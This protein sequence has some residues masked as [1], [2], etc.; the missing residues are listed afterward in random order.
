MLA[1]GCDAGADDVRVERA[2]EPAV[3]G[4]QQ[5]SDLRHALVLFEDRQVGDVPGRF[6]RLPRHPP[7]R[8]GVGAQRL[9]PLL[10]TAQTSRRDQLERTSD[11]LDVLDR[12]DAVAYV[13]LR[14][15]HRCNSG[16]GLRRACLTLP[17]VVERMALFV[18]VEP[19]VFGELRDR[20][21]DLCLCLVAPVAARDLLQ[22]VAVVG[23]HRFGQLG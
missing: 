23:A 22:Q 19:E 10:G 14:F 16:H 4:D 13:A 7:D 5:Q 9:D 8:V 2:G 12:A 20:R 1:S 3:A 15:R 6:G 18:E 11:L 17:A 21:L